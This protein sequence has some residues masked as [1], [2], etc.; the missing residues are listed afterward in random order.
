MSES[1]KEAEQLFHLVFPGNILPGT[2]RDEVTLD[3]SRLL[4][5]PPDSVTKLISGK[6]RYVKRTFPNEQAK[7]LQAQVVQL[8]VECEI[9]PVGEVKKPSTNRKRKK[10]KEAFPD[11]EDFPS[12]LN[13]ESDE[14]TSY[15]ETMAQLQKLADSKNQENNDIERYDFSSQ[16]AEQDKDKEKKKEKDRQGVAQAAIKRRQALFVAENFDDYLPKFDKF[17][18]GGQAHFVFTWHWP[19][20]FVP[21][22]WAVYR[23]LW[24]WSAVIFISSIF[25]PLINILWGATAN[26]LYF[27]HS[28][29][30]IDRIRKKSEP[31]EVDEKLSEAGGTNSTALAAAILAIL[32]LST[33]AYWSEKLSPVFTTLN[34]NL[35][36][37]EQADNP[38]SR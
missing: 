29:R 14:A 27:R 9:E 36:K 26:Y 34:D 15:S 2:D 30:K 17:Q 23:R 38:R 4:K 10:R 24:G 31:D 6:R 8:G 32:L 12:D 20:F 3:L 16:L 35:E 25:W 28:E 22:F 11:P 21:F 5:T 18:K 7:Q 13:E 19:A 33:G 37:I 1:S